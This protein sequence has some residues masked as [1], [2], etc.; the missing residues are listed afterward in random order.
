VAYL[1]V[2]HVVQV[3]PAALADVARAG[4]AAFYLA[5]D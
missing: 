1:P 5:V 2:H 3:F 4:L